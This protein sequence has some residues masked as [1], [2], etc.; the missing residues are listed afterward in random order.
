MQE[1]MPNRTQLLNP[2]SK[3]YVK[4]DTQ[5]ARIMGYKKDRK[6]YKRI[7]IVGNTENVK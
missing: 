3:C 6:P 4:I 1:Y 7:K 5:T 2:K